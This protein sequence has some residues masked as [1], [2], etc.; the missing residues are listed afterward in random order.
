MGLLEA[1][2]W[3]SVH[4]CTTVGFAELVSRVLV[5]LQLGC[6]GAPCW[7]LLTRRSSVRGCKLSGCLFAEKSA[8]LG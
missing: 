3:F 4:N 8:A 1:C 7:A 6:P 5:T 2:W